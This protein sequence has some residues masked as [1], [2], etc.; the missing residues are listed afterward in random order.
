M[1][2]ACVGVLCRLSASLPIIEIKSTSICSSC[3]ALHSSVHRATMASADFCL[4]I[5]YL[6]ISFAM[7][8]I[9]DRQTSR[10]KA[11]DLHSIYL[12]HLHNRCLPDNFGLQTFVPPCPH[13]SCLIYSS[14]SSGQSFACSFL[15]TAPRDDAVAVRLEVPVIK[16]PRG[17]SPPSHFAVRFRLPLESVS[18]D[19]SRHA[20]RTQK[21]GGIY[22]PSHYNLKR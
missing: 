2:G 9:A 13:R 1:T 14:C 16:A 20:R 10:G 4:S 19:A 6:S 18:Y 22:P 11:R 15:P 3:S 21:N 5:R 12:L 8:N 7:K 17:L